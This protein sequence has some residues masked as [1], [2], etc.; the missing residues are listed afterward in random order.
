MH[1]PSLSPYKEFKALQFDRPLDGILRITLNRPDTLDSVSV[2]MHRELLQVW[3]VV[4][5]DE[6]SRALLVIGAGKAFS[7]GGDFGLVEWSGARRALM[8]V[9]EYSR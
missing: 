7:A 3:P 4:G 8:L 1:F 9:Q 2:D 6:N 5:E